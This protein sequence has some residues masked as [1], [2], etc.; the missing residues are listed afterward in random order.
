M[1]INRP[2]VALCVLLVAASP[3]LAAELV[4]I[5]ST[6]PQLAPGQVIDATK[7]LTLAAGTRV[8]LVGEDGKVVRLQGPFSG[9][10][11]TGDGAAGDKGVVRALARLFAPTGPQ[12]TSWGTF[13]GAEALRGDEA[14]NPPEIWSF[15]VLRSETVCLASDTQPTLWRPSA[16]TQLTIILLHLSTGR[17]ASVAFAAGEEAAVWPGEV[18]LLD[19]G[20]YAIR[21]VANQWERRLLVHLVPEDRAAPVELAAWMSDMGCIRQAKQMVSRLPS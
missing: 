9:R 6:A 15:N 13:R 16:E 2:A 18:A 20:E 14:R 8:S 17:E 5:E 1:W 19:G 10:P 3:V 4:V 21:D 12:G 11:T 7:S